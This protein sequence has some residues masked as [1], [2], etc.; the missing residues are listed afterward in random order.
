SSTVDSTPSISYGPPPTSSTLPP[1]NGGQ[2]SSYSVP[3]E[4]STTP[5]YS[6]PLTSSN[7][8][9]PPP[10]ST[11]LPPYNG[12]SSSS[13]VDST[14]SISYGPPP[15]SST[16]PPY[17]GGPSSSYSIPTE[18]S[19]TP[20]YSVPLTSSNSYGPP[21]TT[22]TLPPY[23]GGPSSSTVDS[24]PSA[25][26]PSYTVPASSTTA[27]YSVPLTSSNV[28]VPPPSSTFPPYSVPESSTTAA[29]SVPASSSNVYI[30]PPSSTVA[31]SVPA[32]STSMPAYTP[33]ISSTLPVYT[34]GF[35][36]TT[37]PPYWVPP[38]STVEYSVPLSSTSNVY[39][40]SPSS[41]VAYSVPASSTSMPA[42]TLG[43]TSSLPAYTPG[44]SSTLPPYSVPP[45]STVDY[46]V[47]VTSTS[48]VYVPPPS[49]TLAY[50][51]PASTSSMPEYTP[52]ITST[53]APYT[54]GFTSTTMP[55]YSVP[56]STVAY[57]AASSTLAPYTPGFSSTLPPYTA[58]TSTQAPY[59]P[60][61]TSTLPPYTA[62]TSTLEPYTP[63][64]SS[65]LPPYTATSSTLAPYTPG[66][67]STLPPYTA[68]TS[69][70]APYTPGVSSTFAPY[71]PD[72]S[73]TLP[74]YTAATSTLEPYT[75]GFSSTLPPYT[76]ATSTLQ[77]YTPAV[78]STLPPYTAVTS[79][80][81]PYTPGVSSTLPPY[82]AAT[83]TLEPYTPGVSSTVA[84]TAATSTLGPYTPGVSST[85]PPYTAATS[86]LQPYT[87]GVS[88]TV[89]YTATSSTLEP[90]TPGISTSVPYTA[91]SSTLASYTPGFSSPV[92]YTASVTSTAAY[93][94]AISSTVPY[95]ANIST[96]TLPPYSTPSSIVYP[97]AVPSYSQTPQYTPT[98]TSQSAT[99]TP[100]TTNP[101]DWPEI[102]TSYVQITDQTSKQCWDFQTLHQGAMLSLS[103]C[104]QISSTQVFKFTQPDRKKYPVDSFVLVVSTGTNNLCA[105]L[106]KDGYIAL[107]SCKNGALEQVFEFGKDGSA[108]VLGG[109]YGISGGCIG[110][111]GNNLIGF[112]DCKAPSGGNLV[113]LTWGLKAP[114]V[115]LPDQVVQL[116]MGNGLCLDGSNPGG[117]I[118]TTCTGAASQQ[119]YHLFGQIRNV[120]NGLCWDAVGVYGNGY[121]LQVPVAIQLNVC[122]GYP[123]PVSQFFVRNQDGSMVSGVSFD[124][125]RL[126]PN[127]GL[128]LGTNLCADN[129][130]YALYDK[131]VIGSDA[132]AYPT[133]EGSC[134]SINT[135]MDWRDLS[136][137]AKAKFTNAIKTFQQLP[138]LMGRRNRYHDYSALH[139]FVTSFAHSNPLFLPF[140][141]FYISAFERD[142]QQ[143]LNDPTITIPVWSWSVDAADWMYPETGVLSSSDFGTTGLANPS[144]CVTDGLVGNWIATDNRCLTRFY[145][146]KPQTS[147]YVSMYDESYMMAIMQVNPSTSKP[148]ASYDEFRSVIEGTAHNLFHAAIGDYQPGSNYQNLG[149]MSNSWISVNDITFWLHHANIDKWFSFAQ[150]KNPGF[151]YGGVKTN[152]V[153]ALDTDIIPGFNVPVSKGMNLGSG[154][155]C[156]NYGAYSKSMFSVQVLSGPTY[157]RRRQSGSSPNATVSATD[158]P[159]PIINH[160]IELDTIVAGASTPVSTNNAD[161]KIPVAPSTSVAQ[162]PVKFLNDMG[163]DVDMQRQLEA[164]AMKLKEKVHALMEVALKKYFD[165]TVDNAS[166]EQI[167]K[168]VKLAI[169]AVAAGVEDV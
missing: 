158:V 87:P 48:N 123:A 32:S 132:F 19:T 76:A 66:V 54:P 107:K 71:T 33:G 82:T 97:T 12:G 70:Q 4:S 110:N 9:G 80:L 137:E 3:A 105:E 68:A 160:V 6:V 10:S 101:N 17:N 125:V 139:N 43:V 143:R 23:N 45:S 51:V 100:T 135:R 29:Y 79:T 120:A 92:P 85:L 148:Y 164:N 131:I 1:Y 169:A 154:D 114:L 27:V 136:A 15:T 122:S 155:H 152:G 83:S 61:F 34:P 121:H 153:A 167:S 64:V 126:G 146:P 46:S 49:S 165:A 112:V 16:L 168:A 25:T 104:N 20:V 144:G 53:M 11:T 141:R 162:V 47:P 128:S 30:P 103:Q 93:T 14:P 134:S 99:P 21:P 115:V 60:G 90:Y 50:S 119:W 96:S 77:P 166:A 138:S 36:S 116:K 81:A 86:T 108:K 41:T 124:C 39:V 40:P 78:S 91:A 62:P 55:P 118:G 73:S 59:T 57:T 129:D 145:N 163:M 94:P 150:L 127:N 84:Y 106:G 58:A 157:R 117:V 140:H 67:S 38:S 156:V 8:Y 56:S 2:T 22:S 149:H 44:I 133:K 109:Q 42:Y 52:G 69:T 151:V 161:V 147:G 111:V 5:V 13:T 142:I 26:L 113:N 35:S 98:S 37:M 75:P 130:V 159:A 31:Y 24:T 28:Y 95:S 18:S 63:G 88:S 89:V 7:S 72:V 102:N 74:P 65:T